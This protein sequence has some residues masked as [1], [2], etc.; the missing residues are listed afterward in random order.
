MI[1]SQHS[2]RLAQLVAER[3]KQLL[4]GFVLAQPH[5]V[6]LVAAGKVQGLDEAMQLSEQVDREL[7]GEN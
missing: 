7:S 1:T 5:D 4:E 6:Y 2:R 3:R